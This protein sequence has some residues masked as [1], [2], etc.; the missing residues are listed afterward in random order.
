MSFGALFFGGGGCAAIFAYVHHTHVRRYRAAKPHSDKDDGGGGGGGGGGGA[1][2]SSSSSSSLVS[3]ERN[4]G[5]VGSVQSIHL[6]YSSSAAAA[7][8]H[9]MTLRWNL[10]CG[11]ACCATLSALYLNLVLNLFLNFDDSTR[12]HCT[13]RGVYNALPSISACIGGF[14]R[15]IW[16]LCVVV[17]IWQRVLAGFV[18]HAHHHAALAL[19]SAKIKCQNFDITNS[20]AFDKGGQRYGH[21]KAAGDRQWLARVVAARLCAHTG[22]QLFLVLLSVVS[23]SDNL[24]LHELGFAGFSSCSI[25]NMALTCYVCSRMVVAA[26]QRRGGG[27]GGGGGGHSGGGMMGGSSRSGGGGGVL[28]VAT[29]RASLWTR[30]VLSLAAVA[31]LLGA[32]F[33]F[34]AHQRICVDYRYTWFALGEWLF[35]LFNIIFHFEGEMRELSHVDFAWTFGRK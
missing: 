9:S 10:T 33:F 23:S 30:T 7:P 18:L 14:T 32:V 4:S 2:S 20:A 25:L 17:Y 11:L 27:S 3:A 6:A 13:A 28:A 5:S 35:V 1:S 34:F 15:P 31:S 22:E 8:A 26:Q 12:T 29:A 21:R 24:F 16:S 19:G